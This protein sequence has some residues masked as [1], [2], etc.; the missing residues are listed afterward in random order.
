MTSVV[1]AVPSAPGGL[2]VL[3]D[4]DAMS[5]TLLAAG[6]LDPVVDAWWVADPTPGAAAR[7]RA[8]GLGTVVTRDETREQAAAGPLRATVPAAQRLLVVAAS[9]LL[10][11]GTALLLTADLEARSLEV[12]RLRAL[13][14][15]RRSVLACLVVQHGLVLTA[16]VLV[17]AAIGLLVT[18]VVGPLLVRSDVGLA[19]VPAVRW[20][21]PVGGEA[22]LVGG[23]VA[24]CL[25]VTALVALLQVRRSDT[26]HLRVGDA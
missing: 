12:A 3:A 10:L 25:A 8:L 24:G 15:R 21:W 6:R 22:L 7:V 2:A 20:V 18:V 14:L 19:P 23:L 5:R 16:L 9:V 17:G 26:A 13:G 11:A 4:A 1:P